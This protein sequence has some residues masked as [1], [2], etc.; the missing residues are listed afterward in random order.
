[1]GDWQVSDN[2]FPAPGLPEL[3]DVQLLEQVEID[4]GKYYGSYLRTLSDY[5]PD[6]SVSASGVPS[7][8]VGWFFDLPYNLGL[9][10][11]DNDG[12]GQIDEDDEANILAGERV[13]KDVFIRNGLAVVISLIPGNSPCDGGGNSI[14]H[15]MPFCSGGR[16]TE[17][18]FDINN[19]GLIDER[20]RIEI[21][22]ESLP[23]N[24]MMY[25]GILHKPVVVGDP[26]EEKDR[27]LKIFS[28]SNGTTQTL[29]EKQ[30]ETGFYYW[31]E[32]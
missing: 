27:E 17:P 26:D 4:W 24:G 20:D 23:P 22:G 7:G 25:D 3:K 2:S 5:E 1:M 13:V 28:S 29:W 8:D 30:E 31:K 12:D 19:D 32:H 14:V 9:D 16:L 6:W 15:E 21:N 18:V 10:E 11:L